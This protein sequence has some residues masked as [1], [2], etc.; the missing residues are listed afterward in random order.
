MQN[1]NNVSPDGKWKVILENNQLA[2][3]KLT[4]DKKQFTIQEIVQATKNI[5]PEIWIK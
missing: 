5:A 4:T 2:W 3:I 1:K